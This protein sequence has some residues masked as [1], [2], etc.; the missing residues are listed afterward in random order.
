ML[1]IDIKK[2]KNVNKL[3]NQTSYLEMLPNVE[4]NVKKISNIDDLLQSYYRAL[5]EYIFAH[6]LQECPQIFVNPYV[7]FSYYNCIHYNFYKSFPLF[8]NIIDTFDNLF[9]L[10][11]TM[12]GVI[13]LNLLKALN[14]LI[15]K[16]NDMPRYMALL[17][18][19]EEENKQQ[20]PINL[21]FM[22]ED[23]I[24]YW[25]ID[26]IYV[27]HCVALNEHHYKYSC[28]DNEKKDWR[29][30]IP[31]LKTLKKA[32]LIPRFKYSKADN[33]Y[34]MNIV[35]KGK[36]IT[37]AYDKT[38]RIFKPYEVSFPNDLK[39]LYYACNNNIDLLH[40][41]N[42]NPLFYNI[43]Y[44]TDKLEKT[45]PSKE[46][47]NFLFSLTNGNY[48]NLINLCILFANIASPEILTSKLFLITYCDIESD[49]S[50]EEYFRG[51]INLIF[52]PN[53]RKDISIGF[54]DLSKLVLKKNISRLINNYL[55]GIKAIVV[56]KGSKSLSELQI[57]KIRQYLR[58][59][60]VCGKDNIFGSISFRNVSPIICFSNDIKEINF[61]EENIPCIKINLSHIT[62]INN[63]FTP[64]PKDYEKHYIWLK[65]YLPLYGMH[66]LA[67]K[68]YYK[69]P[70]PIKKSSEFTGS[71][72]SIIDEFL[73][74]CCDKLSSEFIYADTLYNA[75]AFYFHYIY[76]NPPLKRSHFTSIIKGMPNI[77]YKRPHVS[78]TEPNKY[79]FVGIS[80]KDNW[81]ECVQKHSLIQSQKEVSFEKNVKEITSIMPDFNV[82]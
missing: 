23:S 33:P 46:V 65:I 22:I 59:S 38:E 62:D 20:F 76:E 43:N 51:I 30:R 18:Q 69:V 41:K 58:G 39:G 45:A 10:P 37:V 56:S 50:L 26:G 8:E 53:G 40:D 49:L 64:N 52:N 55:E 31:I 79:A 67:E 36:L 68:K 75:Y 71:Q 73:N 61:I 17:W 72:D 14:L 47:I 78:R 77:G 13:E 2:D 32:N 70:L 5:N 28:N 80:L 24:C 7:F 74:I 44:E 25:H 9:K 54:P 63:I 29:K 15:K 57:K 42:I 6:G 3:N 81:K 60:R 19:Y 27:Y 35:Q 48:Q 16:V 34:Y 12:D 4:K 1:E 66:I 11:C 21:F 82:E